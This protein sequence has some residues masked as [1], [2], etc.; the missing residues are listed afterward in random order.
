MIS[1]LTINGTHDR[2]DSSASSLGY[3]A[4]ENVVAQEIVVE[5]QMAKCHQVVLV[6]L[7]HF[8]QERQVVDHGAFRRGRFTGRGLPRLDNRPAAAPE[9]RA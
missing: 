3:P 7:E 6:V 4:R 5:A 1:T 9:S 8:A 2:P